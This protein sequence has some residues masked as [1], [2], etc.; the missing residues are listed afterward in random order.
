MRYGPLLKS[1]P[2]RKQMS[3]VLIPFGSEFDGR[4]REDFPA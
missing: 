4:T 2:M 3:D 1:W